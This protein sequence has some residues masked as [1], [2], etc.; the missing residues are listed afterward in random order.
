[1]AVGTFSKGQRRSPYLGSGRS[2]VAE[3]E[4]SNGP[5]GQ[6]R[7]KNVLWSPGKCTPLLDKPTAQHVATDL[8]FSLE[9]YHMGA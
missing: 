6:G 5:T 3:Y 8:L 2:K 4:K 1:M 7:W 9:C